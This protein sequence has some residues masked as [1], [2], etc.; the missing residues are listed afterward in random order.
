MRKH[1]KVRHAENAGPPRHSC[2]HCAAAFRQSYS[3]VVHLRTHTGEKPYTCT[4]CPAQFKR[5]HHLRAHARV[6][7]DLSAR[8]RKRAA[9]RPLLETVE[10]TLIE[11]TGHVTLVSE[12]NQPLEDAT[13]THDL[14]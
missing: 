12:S 9:E 1:M 11:D 5:L 7:A 13:A 8:R 14:D 6:C 2:P 4:S 10:F 3:L